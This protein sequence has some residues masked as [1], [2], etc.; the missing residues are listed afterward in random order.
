MDDYLSLRE[1]FFYFDLLP[2]FIL[3]NLSI[4][5]KKSLEIKYQ[6]QLFFNKFPFECPT[7]KGAIP[8]RIHKPKFLK[9]KYQLFYHDFFLQSFLEIC[10]L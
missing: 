9:P 3:K 4:L 2:K 8:Y 6:L 10:N 1:K 7:Q 5:P